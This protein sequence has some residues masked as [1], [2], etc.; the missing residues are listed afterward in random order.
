[1]APAEPL[2]AEQG[3]DLLDLGGR[4]GAA[5]QHPGK[6]LGISGR[7]HAVR[8]ERQAL[9]RQRDRPDPRRAVDRERDMDRPIVPPFRIFAGAVERV[10]D[11]DPRGGQA[12]RI[13]G[14]LLGENGVAGPP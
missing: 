12:R 5:D 14:A 7:R 13:V 2:G 4:P 10:D 9:R 6:A 8:T 11:P 3:G 1:L